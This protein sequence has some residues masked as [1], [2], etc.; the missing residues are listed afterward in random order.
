M[1]GFSRRFDGSYVNAYNMTLNG[2]I[3]RPTIIRSQTCDKYVHTFP[4]LHSTVLQGSH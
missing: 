4:L 2:D 1:C 3:G